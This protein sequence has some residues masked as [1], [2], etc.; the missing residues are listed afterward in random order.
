MTEKQPKLTF[1]EISEKAQKMT[2]EQ[3][4]HVPMLMVEGD[5]EVAVCQ[6]A[7]VADTAEGRAGQMLMIGEMLAGSIDFGVLQQ[8]LFV[9]EGWMSVVDNGQI[10]D[11]PPSQD[12]ERLEVLTVSG[13]DMGTGKTQMQVFEMQR[14]DEGQLQSLE[15]PARLP[16]TE[17]TEA[18][19][20]LL[21]AFVIGFLGLMQG[22]HD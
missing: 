8:V 22:D 1:E 17:T 11:I 14:D 16:Q 4:S 18:D 3:G 6:I 7:E 21:T 20:P 5:K 2:L 10:P 9:T 13:L 12:P 19:S 15:T